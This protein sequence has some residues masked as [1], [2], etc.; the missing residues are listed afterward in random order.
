MSGSAKKTEIKVAKS[1]QDLMI[2]QNSRKALH[3]VQLFLRV[4]GDHEA[5]R[6][7]LP[8]KAFVQTPRSVDGAQPCHV[9][10]GNDQSAPVPANKLRHKLYAHPTL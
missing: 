7:S 5:K 2:A 4:L 9:K 8:Y 10:Y 1:K 3:F 6:N